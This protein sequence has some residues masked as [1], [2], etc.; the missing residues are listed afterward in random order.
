MTPRP[1]LPGMERRRL[2]LGFEG[3]WR[4]GKGER[5]EESE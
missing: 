1:A 3:R 4:E 2:D 5:R